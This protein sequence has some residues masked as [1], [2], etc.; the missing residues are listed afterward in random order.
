MIQSW[1]LRCLYG[2]LTGCC[3][4]QHPSGALPGRQRGGWWWI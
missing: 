1:P 3:S 4:R 2:L